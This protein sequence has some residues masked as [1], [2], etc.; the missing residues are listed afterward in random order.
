MECE[1]MAAD[2]DREIAEAVSLSSNRGE[3]GK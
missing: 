2:D 3:R 1:F